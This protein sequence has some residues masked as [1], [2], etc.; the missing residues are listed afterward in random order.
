MINEL[1][2]HTLPQKLQHN[3]KVL[4]KPPVP[5]TTAAERNEKDDLD[6][7]GDLDVTTIDSERSMSLSTAM[8]KPEDSGGSSDDNETSVAS[9]TTTAVNLQNGSAS[10]KHRRLM[11]LDQQSCSFLSEVAVVVEMQRIRSMSCSD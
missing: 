5:P 9:S 8:L 3:D 1:N 11:S 7:I 2:T 10:R 6:I 4:P